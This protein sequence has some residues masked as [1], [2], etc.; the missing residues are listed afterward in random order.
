MRIQWWETEINK[1]LVTHKKDNNKKRQ[2]FWDSHTQTC[3]STIN[4]LVKMWKVMQCQILSKNGLPAQLRETHS[5]SKLQIC[6][7]IKLKIMH[8]F[9]IF[10]AVQYLVNVKTN[11]VFKN[12]LTA[13]RYKNGCRSKML[14]PLITHESYGVF[15][16]LATLPRSSVNATFPV[17]SWRPQRQLGSSLIGLA[18][19][20]ELNSTV[21]NHIY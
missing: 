3:A 18:S 8:F 1:T 14:C 20:L 10:P 2:T 4:V 21:C 9:A 17:Y 19:N 12:K 15:M 5:C 13:F 11:N 6:V 16:P 7:Q